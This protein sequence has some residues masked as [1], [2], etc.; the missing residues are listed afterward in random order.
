MSIAL[1]G[2]TF[3]PVHNGHLAIASDLADYLGKTH[4]KLMPCGIPVHRGQS[5]TPAEHRKAMIDLA[6]INQPKLGVELGEIESTEPSYTIHS[7]RRIRAQ[8][9]QKKA[10][11]M[12]LGM[13]AL[14]HLHT[15]H[16]WEC[17]LNYCHILVI[18]RPGAE[19]PSDPT[20]T[21]WIQ[22]NLCEIEPRSVQKPAGALF[23]CELR[24][25]DISSTQIRH[26]V[27]NGEAIH[28]Y[29]VE[30]VADYISK[31]NLYK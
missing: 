17:L 7:L 11:F 14:N 5:I 21:R 23:F 20:L 8:I 27:R 4:V 19:S 12:C 3:D 24:L 9:D 15:W 18:S 13:D 30:H 22:K 10:L 31:N 6:V 16:E 29:V 25:L 26:C 1:L 28:S 2:G